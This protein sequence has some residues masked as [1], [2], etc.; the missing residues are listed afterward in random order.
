ME[1]VF[2]MVSIRQERDARQKAT[3]EI[4]LRIGISSWI[5]APKCNHKR[6]YKKVAEKHYHRRG[7]GNVATK[8]EIRMMRP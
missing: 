3:A 5:T 1:T 6:A 2:G 4:D 7:E 8:A